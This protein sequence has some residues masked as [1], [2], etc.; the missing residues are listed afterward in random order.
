MEGMITRRRF[1]Q[2]SSAAAA[3]AL[4]GTGGCGMKGSDRAVKIVVVGG[5]AAGLGVSARLVRL[6]NQHQHLLLRQSLK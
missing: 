3:L 6:L 4:A 5:G 1:V 2:A